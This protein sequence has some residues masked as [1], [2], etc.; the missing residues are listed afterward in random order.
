[1]NVTFLNIR[2]VSTIVE[3]LKNYYN[4]LL[5][6][7]Q[8]PASSVQFST[9]ST[10][11]NHR[12]S[13]IGNHEV[14]IDERLAFVNSPYVRVD[15]SPVFIYA[16]ISI[17]T[18]SVYNGLPHR[19]YQNQHGETVIRDFASWYGINET[20]PI[21]TSAT[22]V[23]LRTNINGTFLTDDELDVL[24]TR[25]YQTTLGQPLDMATVTVGE[26]QMVLWGMKE[27]RANV[28][29]LFESPIEEQP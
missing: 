16:P 25:H 13:Y 14:T 18:E 19:T 1:M 21:R 17:L 20:N 7:T 6:Q 12:F 27:F 22:H 28:D 26:G 8:N 23:L 11:D 15:L 2:R 9:T 3:P 10:L 4:D 5:A 29:L 24:K